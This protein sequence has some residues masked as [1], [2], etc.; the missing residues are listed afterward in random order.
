MIK[1]LKKKPKLNA[2][3]QHALKEFAALGWPGDCELQS[4]ICDHLIELLGILG[5]YGHGDISHF[6]L[7]N[8]FDKLARFQPISSLAG[9]IDEWVYEWLIVLNHGKEN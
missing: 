4:L 8:L 9:G 1:W 2:L 5:G 3:Q 7:L 6:Y